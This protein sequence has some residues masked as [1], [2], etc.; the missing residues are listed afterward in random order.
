VIV[1]RLHYPKIRGRLLTLMNRNVATNALIEE[2]L[3]FVSFTHQA[4]FARNDNLWRRSRFARRNRR[5]TLI[6]GFLKSDKFEILANLSRREEVREAYGFPCGTSQSSL[7]LISRLNRSFPP[8][9]RF[10]RK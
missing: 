6:D 8:P 9:L 7:V 4:S 10:L 3:W 1:S 2:I 5:W